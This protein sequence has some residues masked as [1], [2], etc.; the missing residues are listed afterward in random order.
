[1]S[2]RDEILEAN[3]AHVEA[4]GARADLERAPKRKVA[5]LMCLDARLDLAT[6]AGLGAGDACVIRNAG[7]RASDD[8]IRSLVIS[9]KLLGADEW[10]VIHHS[11]CGMEV[12]TNELMGDLLAQSLDP[13]AIGPDGFYDVGEG[14]GSPEGRTIDWLPISDRQQSVVD[15][16]RTI[17][18]HPLVAPGI[19]IYGFVY[20]VKTGRLDEVPE[21]TAAGRP[22]DSQASVS[23]Q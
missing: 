22:G 7:G 1:V 21:A 13:A 3:A 20:D 12:V 8:V 23:A 9:H 5:V 11:D 4:F 10:F 18:S 2:V 6:F 19:S 15:D 14:P 16:V 17:R